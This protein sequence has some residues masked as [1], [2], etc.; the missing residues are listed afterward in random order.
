[1]NFNFPE[2]KEEFIDVILNEIIII[3]GWTDARRY[4]HNHNEIYELIKKT[5]FGFKHFWIAFSDRSRPDWLELSPDM[6]D[7]I[8][9]VAKIRIESLYN[10]P[11]YFDNGWG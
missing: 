7:D 1:M 6:V 3:N 5:I 4:Y 2:T 9:E 10:D 11:E 8:Y